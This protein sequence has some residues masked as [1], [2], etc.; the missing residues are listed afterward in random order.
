MTLRRQ[1]GLIQINMGAVFSYRA[2]VGL[3]AARALSVNV[4]LC[5][6]RQRQI[7]TEKE[8]VW[9]NKARVNVCWHL[10]VSM[11]G[12]L[13][14]RDPQGE[15]EGERVVDKRITKSKEGLSYM[16]GDR[17]D[18]RGGEEGMCLTKSHLTQIDCP[19]LCQSQLSEQ[20]TTL[21]CV[22]CV[23]V[24]LCVGLTS[25]SVQGCL[26]HNLLLYFLKCYTL[27]AI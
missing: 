20:T 1:T 22:L 15:G 2:E 17:R 24:C 18:L 14:C 19:P 5:V 21:M 26:L 23:C 16:Q 3:N 8:C 12:R 4:W 7:H 11:H 27:S 6:S 13:W 9:E 10:S 25:D